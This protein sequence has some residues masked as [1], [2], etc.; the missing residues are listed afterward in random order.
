LTVKQ[1]KIKVAGLLGY[2]ALR[3]EATPELHK[4]ALFHI[5]HAPM[6]ASHNN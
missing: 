6:T 3:C 5:V 4:E 2:L 1:V